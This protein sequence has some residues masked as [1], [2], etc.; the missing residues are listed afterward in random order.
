M[1]RKGTGKSNF[2]SHALGARGPAQTLVYDVCAEHDTLTTYTPSHRRGEQ[3]DAELEQVT[4]RLVLGPSADG[5]PEIFAVEELSRFCSPRSPPP[6]PVYEILD[7]NR[8][9]RTP[10]GDGLGFVGITRRPSQ[11]HTD[12]VELAD[13]LVIFRLTGRSDKRRLND[14]HAGLGDAAA[15]LEDYHFI[16]ADGAGYREYPPVP[17]RDTTGSL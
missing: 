15:A 3:A 17:E 6:E 13:R 11:V 5:R 1:G 7:M 8:H 10:S 14:T 12:A 16:V 2:L 4:E 9:Y